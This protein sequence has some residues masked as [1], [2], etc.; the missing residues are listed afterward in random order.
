[1]AASIA[2]AAGA[3]NAKNVAVPDEADESRSGKRSTL[4]LTLT[5]TVA[6]TSTATFDV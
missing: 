1:M 6:L 3:C 2:A 4:S 5:L